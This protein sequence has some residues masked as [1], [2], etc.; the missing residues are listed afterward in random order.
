MPRS[1]DKCDVTAFKTFCV[2][3]MLQFWILKISITMW[4][5]VC[6]HYFLSHP[7]SQMQ[8]N[9]TGLRQS[10]LGN[11]SWVW[12]NISGTLIMKTAFSIH[13][14]GSL[15]TF[16]QQ[17]PVATTSFCRA[18]RRKN[19][20][21]KSNH[22]PI[23][24][25][26]GKPP[27]APPACGA[28]STAMWRCRCPCWVGGAAAPG[29]HLSSVPTPWPLASGSPAA[30]RLRGVP[31]H[32]HRGPEAELK[33]ILVSQSQS[34]LNPQKAMGRMVM[35]LDKSSVYWLQSNRPMWRKRSLNFSTPISPTIL[36]LNMKTLL[37][38]MC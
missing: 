26:T 16:S 9:F 25:N 12:K 10:F 3:F 38:Q 35:P 29:S 1:Q 14:L 11:Q 7:F 37:C 24:R 13:L 17:E 31:S 28:A 2:S 23:T 8:K 6:P 4:N 22:P 32:C 34:S 5:Q 18:N 19:T 36:N 20:T 30:P 33:S 15:R 21:L 27:S